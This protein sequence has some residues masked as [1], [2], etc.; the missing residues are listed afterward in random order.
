MVLALSHYRVCNYCQKICL[1]FI[2]T[3]CKEN[4]VFFVYNWIQAPHVVHFRGR[5]LGKS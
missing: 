4:G 2:L 3:H 1:Y 5:A